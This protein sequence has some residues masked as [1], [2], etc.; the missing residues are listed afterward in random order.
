MSDKKAF[1]NDC[2]GRK[3]FADNLLKLIKNQVDY[4]SR[5]I[6]IK[7]DFGLGKT[8]FAKEFEKFICEHL[9]NAQD[10][11]KIYPH[12]VNIWKE[13][14]TNEPLLALLYA[15]ENIADKYQNRCKKVAVKIAKYLAFI[16]VPIIKFISNIRFCGLFID[17]FWVFIDEAKN[18]LKAIK[19]HNK[20]DNIKSY[21]KIT[22]NI[23]KAF[24]FHKDKKFVIIVDEI[25]RCM[26]EYAIRFLETLKHFFDI[27]G[28]YF[29][30]MFNENYLQKSLADRF[31]YIDFA[32]WKDKFI[33]L[34]FDL[35]VFHSQERFIEYLV[36][37]YDIKI[38]A[39]NRCMYIAYN[40]EGSG[41]DLSHSGLFGRNL[42]SYI[43]NFLNSL[44]INLNYRQLNMLCFR[45]N[46][47]I[48][49]LG[50]EYVLVDCLMCVILKDMFGDKIGIKQGYNEIP[51]TYYDI[52][53]GRQHI[54]ELLNGGAISSP[55]ALRT[56]LP[57]ATNRYSG[58]NLELTIMQHTQSNFE[59][60]KKVAEFAILA[61]EK[62]SNMFEFQDSLEQLYRN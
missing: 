39:H 37:K 58:A 29:V 30:L 60:N 49:I 10:L 23:I 45:L 2:F 35:S 55:V 12:Y 16:S 40:L 19:M 57:K 14:Y 25:D 27:K 22:Q 31:D 59:A 20:F 7:A 1:N 9:E 18:N 61:N 44:D 28:L 46:L 43:N 15:L 17:N 62:Q 47:A 26:P 24:E 51:F 48:E 4:E 11:P 38:E 53:K 54:I 42:E 32:L 21:E 13:N 34:E 36:R 33:D 5:V 6:A 56:F 41:G 50:N 8:F 3:E 52:A